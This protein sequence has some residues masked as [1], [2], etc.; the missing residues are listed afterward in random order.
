MCRYNVKKERHKQRSSTLY[1]EKIITA[2]STPGV[3]QTKR[4]ENV[5][6]QEQ[7]I[8]KRWKKYGWVVEVS[9]RETFISKKT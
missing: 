4:A 1:N 9:R 5:K 8:R 6:V 3:N 2:A 7:T